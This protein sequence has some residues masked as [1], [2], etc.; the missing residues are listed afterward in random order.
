MGMSLIYKSMMII[1]QDTHAS[2]ARG[3]LL[4]FEPN[5]ANVSNL[6]SCFY[7][8]MT[9]SGKAPEQVGTRRGCR[10]STPGMNRVSLYFSG[11]NRGWGGLNLTTETR[12]KRSGDREWV[13]FEENDPLSVSA[14]SDSLANRGPLGR[15]S[16]R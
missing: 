3:K 8:I 11:M 13:S 10:D 9:G 1:S 16:S 15:R 6:F 4:I 2:I 14:F 12:E 7:V 5:H